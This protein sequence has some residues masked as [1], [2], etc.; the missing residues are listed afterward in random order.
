[1]R[2]G[3]IYPVPEPLDP[4]TSLVFPLLV[5]L[6]PETL[7]RRIRAKDLAGRQPRYRRD[8]AKRTM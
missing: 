7:R 3:I 8:E 5:Y 1:M 4:A 2:V 6:L